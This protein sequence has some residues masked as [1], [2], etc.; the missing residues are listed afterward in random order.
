MIIG[1]A[2]KEILRSL[3]EA[4]QYK[5]YPFGYESSLSSLKMHIWDSHF[6]DSNEVERV[7]SMLRL[8]RIFGKRSETCRSEISQEVRP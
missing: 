5:V 1:A 4:S 6:Q 3:L 7:R 2:A 8:C